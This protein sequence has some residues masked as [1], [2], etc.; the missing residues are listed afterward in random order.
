MLPTTNGTIFTT[1]VLAY[2]TLEMLQGEAQGVN[3]RETWTLKND[4]GYITWHQYSVMLREISL[5]SE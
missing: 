1:Y 5:I 2:T 4:V 3:L